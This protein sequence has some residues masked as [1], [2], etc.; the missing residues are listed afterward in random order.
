[1]PR[2]PLFSLVRR[3]ARLAQLSLHTGEDAATVAGRAAER[4]G[5]SRRT[6]LAGTAAAAAGAAAC[7]TSPDRSAPPVLIVGA[8]LA[9]LVTAWR[10]EQAGI[11]ARV[12][13]GQ[14]RFGGRM[15]SLRNYFS[16]G[17]VAELGG[18]L[19]D[20]GHESI[21]R[22]A[23][24]LGIELNDLAT[25]DP[26]LAKTVWWFEG[27]R[28][29]EEVIEGFR[30]LVPRIEGDLATLRGDD[31][32][33]LEPNG[34]EVLDRMSIAAWL[35]R[36]G[37]SGW[38]RRLIE[39]AYTTEYGLEPGDQSALNFLTMIDPNPDS[40]AIFGESDERFHVSGGNDRIVH[41]V[42]GRLHRPVETGSVLEAVRL[43]DDGTVRCSFLRDGTAFSVDAPEVVLA[44]P[45]TML[46][47]VRI[48]APLPDAKRRAIAEL[49]YGTNA[50]LMVG[51][52]DRPWRRQGSDGSVVAD[53]PF[54]LT[55]ETSRLQP[56]RSGILTNFT[57]GAHGVEIGAGSD[58][59]Q[60][61][62][63]VRDLERLWPGISSARS[64]ASKQA[65]F[66]W[67]T[68]RWVKGSYASYLPG[69]WTS[70][71]GLEA[72][73]A[74]PLFFAGEHCSLDFQGFMN[75]ASES[76]ER[77][78]AEILARRGVARAA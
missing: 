71:R 10:L 65:R 14:N 72:Q 7:R 17:Q 43:L 18:E 76:G 55:W 21:R 49:G 3:S 15:L 53:L 45:F 38:M 19:I 58:A 4:R 6:F 30:H 29:E 56:G 64:E 75:G 78:A 16:D 36:A 2:S 42:A 37:V 62:A 40:F 77:A 66:H 67:P 57:G 27:R 25:D 69:Q 52:D 74:P 12:M 1:M 32:T 59:S 22:I 51:F 23:Q 70:V 44:I 33:A 63:L 34:G 41:A 28:S 5:L 73:A 31:V 26:S 24:D 13:E 48:D 20:T 39:V 8:G 11:P 35:D 54:Q 50:K 47:G 60:A 9:G 46:R 68:N 61:A